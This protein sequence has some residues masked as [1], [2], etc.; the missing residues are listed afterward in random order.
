MAWL[1]LEDFVVTD[2]THDEAKA[3]LAVRRALASVRPRYLDPAAV[4]IDDDRDLRGA[5]LRFPHAGE[6]GVEVRLHQGD[7]WFCL[8][9]PL[10]RY[11]GYL[12]DEAFAGFLTGLFGGSLRRTRRWRGRAIVETVCDWLDPT[13]T[14]RS[15]SSVPPLRPLW[16]RAV[17]LS[18]RLE[19][20]TLSFDRVPAVRDEP[21]A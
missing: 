10:G 17:P 11:D 15:L 18:E 12:D 1:P 16:R 7:G 13:G 21:P 3:V 20:H 6:P 2:E 4:L 5:A 8:K 9:S 19:R 14:R